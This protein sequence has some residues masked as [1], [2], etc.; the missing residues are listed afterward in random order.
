M[1]TWFSAWSTFP[2]GG[3]IHRLSRCVMY[4]AIDPTGRITTMFMAQT[5]VFGLTRTGGSEALLRWKR[6]RTRSL[7]RDSDATGT[8]SPATQACRWRPRI[9]KLRALQQVSL[10]ISDSC[11]AVDFFRRSGTSHE[12]GLGAA[13]AE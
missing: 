13:L 11:R 5:W 1:P 6:A 8:S 9:G 2:S 4:V 12:R 10:S 7:A 3:I